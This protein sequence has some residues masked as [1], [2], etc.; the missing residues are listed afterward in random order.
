VIPERPAKAPARPAAPLAAA[1]APKAPAAAPGATAAP[2]TPTP[3]QLAA[4]ERTLAVLEQKAKRAEALEGRVAGMAKTE[5]AKLPEDARKYILSIAGKDPASQLDA[6]E[7]LRESRLLRQV[8]G[9]AKPATTTPAKA[10]APAPTKVADPDSA[11][12]AQYETLKNSGQHLR[13]A[14]L[15]RAQHAAIERARTRRA[16]TH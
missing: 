5:L 1:P 3:R 13:A 7:K 9:S 14:Q 4:R 10:A 16:S 12:L 8:V 6:I 2:A 11:A 15:L